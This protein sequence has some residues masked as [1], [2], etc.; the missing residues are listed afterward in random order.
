MNEFVFP[1]IGEI[2]WTNPR[3]SADETR[4]RADEQLR[5]LLA[6][7]ARHVPLYRD[8]WKRHGF[9]P[10][11]AKSVDDLRHAPMVDKTPSSKPATSPLTSAAPAKNSI[12]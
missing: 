6:H 5:R 9:D 7:A 2:F 10:R 8:L 3:R 11:S 4:E 1:S 12:R